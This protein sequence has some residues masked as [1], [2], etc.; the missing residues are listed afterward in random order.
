MRVRPLDKGS[1]QCLVV[2]QVAISTHECFFSETWNEHDR[3]IEFRVAIFN[4]GGPNGI[5]YILD[6]L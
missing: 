3:S 1:A 4:L 6:C 2:Q 5:S